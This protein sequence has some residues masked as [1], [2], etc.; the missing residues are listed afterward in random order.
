MKD[1]FFVSDLHGR[2]DRYGTLFTLIEEECPAA[3]FFG[4]DLLPVG[5]FAGPS[6]RPDQIRVTEDSFAGMLRALHGR[7][8][9][10]YPRVFLIFGNDDPRVLEP[11]FMELERRG[12]LEY[13]HNRKRPFGRHFVY[14]YSCVPPTPFALKDWERYDVSRYVDPGS[15]SPEEGRYSVPVSQRETKYR[16]IKED[17]ELLA[18]D[19]DLGNAVILFHTPPYQTNLD[20]AAL[21]GKMIDHAPLDVHVGSIA[22]RQFIEARQPLLSLHGHIHESARLTGSWRDTIGNTVCVSAA[23]D[24]TELALVRFQLGN[25]VRVRRDLL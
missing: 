25:P 16:T 19:D 13:L 18:G 6:S 14:G 11:V 12:L 20:R 17:L 22:V 10:A 5:G 21:D 2:G 23:H 4:G 1:C 9:S 3:V 15:I 8:A 7:M 24:G